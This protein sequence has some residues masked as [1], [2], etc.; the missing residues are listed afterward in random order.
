MRGV[1]AGS[2]APERESEFTGLK[3]HLLKYTGCAYALVIV[4]RLIEVLSM[5]AGSGVLAGVATAVLVAAF[6][7]YPVG[8][9]VERACRMALGG[10]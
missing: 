1:A 8:I 6:I 9:A 2:G 7:A 3:G 4:S 5:R 10:R